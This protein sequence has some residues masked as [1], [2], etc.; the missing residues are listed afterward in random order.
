VLIDFGVP[1][2]VALPSV[3]AYRTVAVWPATPV[4]MAAIP[5][6]PRTIARW[7][8]EDSARA[9]GPASAS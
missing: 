9:A 2:E 8:R 3:L 4:A 5:A 1:A 7:E 6:L